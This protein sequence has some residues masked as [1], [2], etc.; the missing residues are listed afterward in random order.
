M[1]V[2]IFQIIEIVKIKFAHEPAF[3]NRGGRRKFLQLF[4]RFFFERRVSAHEFFADEIVFEHF[5]HDLIVVR[6]AV[7]H[8]AQSAVH[9]LGRG[10]R[11]GD[12]IFAERH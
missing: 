4:F 8:V 1:A 10:G 6:A 7:G 12:E 3:R 9:A 11:T 5:P 2:G